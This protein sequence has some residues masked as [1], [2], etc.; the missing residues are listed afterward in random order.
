TWVSDVTTVGRVD[1]TTGI[2]TNFTAQEVSTNS[3]CTVTATFGSLIDSTG[4]LTV[5]A[6]TVDYIQIRDVAGGLGNIVTTATYGVEDT[7]EFYV[8]AYNITVDYLY[9]VSVTWDSDADTVGQVTSPGDSTTFEAQSVDVDSQCTVTAT[10][11]AISNSTGD[12]TVLA[13]RVDEIMIRT[14]ANG[15]GNVLLTATFD[16]DDTATYYAAGYNDT[17]GYLEDLA[18]AVWDVTVV[19]I[20]T[21][22]SPGASTTFTATA[23]GDT[24][25]T[26]SFTYDSVT[27]T[28]ES[29]TINVNALDQPPAPPGKP[30]LKVKGTDK[31]E[32]TW[33][34]NTELDLASY[35]IYRS[36]DPDDPGSW[37]IVGTTDEN[38]TFFTDKDLDPDKKYSYR[39]TAV[40]DLGQ[41]SDPSEVAYATTEAEGFPWLFLLIPLIIAIVMILLALFLWKKKK[42]E[43]EAMPPEGVAPLAEAPPEEAPPMEEAPM[44]EEFTPEEEYEEGAPAEEYEEAPTETE[45]ETEFEEEPETEEEAPP[46]TPPPPPPPPP[47]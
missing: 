40:D 1:T 26:A 7:D 37:V 43:E 2:W 11:G 39:I 42:R 44:E 30:G 15:L 20:G 5:L 17:V 38:T 36:T 27:I 41:E 22:T 29:G 25:I 24:T 3:Q 9:D 6:P 21:V 18:D 10:Y 47:E 32:I 33:S 4:L 14:A 31:I 12:L 13:P 8:A 35:R 19:G 28:E 23:E 45:E 46:T 16:V 34:A